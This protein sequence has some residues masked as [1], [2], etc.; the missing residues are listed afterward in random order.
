MKK[1]LIIMIAFICMFG[2]SMSITHNAYADLIDYGNGLIYD[3]DLDITWMQN[4]NYAGANMT[5][6]DAN[7]WA[8]NLVYTDPV[9]GQTYTDWRLPY[10]NSTET[11]YAID[12]F[13]LA[14]DLLNYN[15]ITGEMTHLY[16][17]EM[18][19]VAYVPPANWS[20]FTN[21]QDSYYWYAE[22]VNDIQAMAFCM[23]NGCQGTPTKTNTYYALA[24][25]N[26]TPVVPEP[27]SST[28]FIVGGVALGFRQF[29]KKINT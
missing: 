9:Y 22:S 17:L 4:A 6:A 29:R 5:W 15:T 16:Y 10:A 18:G 19:G 25:R 7:T 1:L 2:I 21:V 14:G 20:P 12:P 28:L 26:G 3:T 13:D 23:D 27:I 11:G 8:S 24:V